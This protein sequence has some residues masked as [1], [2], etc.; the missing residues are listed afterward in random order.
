M[1]KSVPTTI[2]PNRILFTMLRVTDLDKSIA[3]Y[4]DMLGMTEL[5]R[6]TFPDV[7]FTAVFMGYG[8]RKT[9]AVLELTYN[10]GD[11]SYEHGTA[12][13]NIS[14]EVDDVFAL[15]TYLI[16]HNVE[17]LRPAGEINIVS[18]ELGR[19]HTLA[20]IAD[21]DGYRIE[22]MQVMAET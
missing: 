6:E 21:P 9:E 20:H 1:T 2:A 8:D 12:F 17:I 7:E 3:F 16:E 22:L 10:W 15:E 19:K 5:G 13:G 11:T 14:L 4:T 18:T